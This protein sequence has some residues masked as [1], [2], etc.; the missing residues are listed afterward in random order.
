MLR[1]AERNLTGIEQFGWTRTLLIE[2]P[3]KVYALRQ[4]EFDVKFIEK[5]VQWTKT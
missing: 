4:Y 5:K 2:E 1:V 3:P